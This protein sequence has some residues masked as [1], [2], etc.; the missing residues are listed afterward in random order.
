MDIGTLFVCIVLAG[1]RGVYDGDTFTC[2]DKT[3]VRLWGVAA[4]EIAR[5]AQM[6]GKEARDFMRD[7]IAGKPLLCVVKGHNGGR[8]VAKCH[9]PGPDIGAA[10]IAAGKARDCPSFSGG[11]YANAEVAASRELPF[12]GYCQP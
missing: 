4:P 10:L 7:L 3:K 2:E 6:G 1:S 8:V 5:P 11:H 9:L 12:P